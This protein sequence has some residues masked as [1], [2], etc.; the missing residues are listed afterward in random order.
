[1]TLTFVK[2]IIII[3]YIFIVILITAIR[4]M[5]DGF[6]MSAFTFASDAFRAQRAKTVAAG[7]VAFFANEIAFG[8]LDRR[9]AFA[10]DELL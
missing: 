7:A 5:F 2:L 4:T 10:I 6:I 1:M 9:N 3:I 8:L